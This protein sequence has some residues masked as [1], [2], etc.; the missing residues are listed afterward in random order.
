[1]TTKWAGVRTLEEL[2]DRCKID[3]ETGCWIYP[4]SL[5]SRTNTPRVYIAPGLIDEK[6]HTLTAR[7]AGWLL[8]GRPL[9]AKLYVY[10]AKLF[11]QAACCNPDHSAVG[12]RKQMGQRQSKQGRF[13][14]DPTR[15]IINRG[16]YMKQAVPPETV[17]RAKELVEQGAQYKVAAAQLGLHPQTV[18]KIAKGQH[19]QQRAVRGSSIFNLV[20]A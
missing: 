3:E 4:S 19:A 10:C 1:M 8:A 5:D 18:A 14:G 12:T 7:R 17:Q 13:S 2:R 20:P 16:N 15:S 9:D 11:C 6:V